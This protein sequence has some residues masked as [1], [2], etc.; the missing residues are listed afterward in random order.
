MRNPGD[1]LVD[2]LIATEREILR[3]GEPPFHA[4]IVARPKAGLRKAFASVRYFTE[5]KLKR[6]VRGLRARLG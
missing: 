6:L 4:V 1:D 3:A 5:P 2:R